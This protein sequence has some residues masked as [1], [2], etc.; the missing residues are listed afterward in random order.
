[1]LINISFHFDYFPLMVVAAIAWGTPILLTLLKLK[2]VPSVIVEI[3]LG[4][5]I[6][7]FLLGS[8]DHE[9][10]RILE[11]FALT[12]FI[13]LMFLGGLEID[14]DQIMASLPRK[15]LTY[16]HFIK[17]PLLVGIVFFF[18]SIILAYVGTL[19]LSNL[20]D[21]P[22]V[23]YFSLIMVTTS[24]GIVLPVLKDR[25]EI[26]NRYGQMIIIAAAIADILSIILFTFTA[27]II[28]NGFQPELLYILGL[29]IIF[30]VFYSLGNKVKNVPVL[31][32][33]AFQLSH[34]ASQIRIRGSIL[35]IMLFVVIAQ[36]IGE[37]A[38]LLG[39]FLIGLV[40]STMLHR[41]RSVML[42]KLD[43]MGYGFFI[44]IFFIMVGIEFDPSAFLEFDQSLI[45]F[46][47]FLLITLFVVKII[48]AFLWRQLFGL[49]KAM[50]GG[51]LMSS[52][53]SLIIAAS[54]IGLEMGVITPGINA[55]FVVMA[56]LTCFISPVVFNWLSPG[57]ILKGD[58]TIIIGASSTAVLLARRLIMHG[59]KSVIVEND[60]ARADEL[61]AKGLN[62]IEGDGC[63]AGLYEELNLHPSDFVI[64]ETGSPETDHEICKLLRN[65]LMHDN[66]ITRS[67]T[68]DIELKLK[69]LGVETIDVIGVLATT[70]ENLIIRPTTYH[71]L[72]ESFEN[73]SVE[74]ILITNKN[75]DGLQVKEVPFH[76][77]AILMMV[78]RENSFYIPH[79]D[80][81]FRTGDILHVFGTNNALQNTKEKVG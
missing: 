70:I 60:K 10:F 81:Y 39:A 71:A 43:G 65:E 1:M 38:V 29:F 62:C 49:K 8:I 80:T 20:I 61:K 13:F 28:K 31:K 50:A 72:V 24:V 67:S 3:I 69:Y 9:S 56:I 14:V 66:I 46:L 75:V 53:L 79:G 44:P 63:N 5:F 27:F 35:L 51:F 73:F 19:F 78:K 68:S 7:K 58:K 15:R 23:W 52:R 25:G 74:E 26:K 33:L 11:F 22:H 12:G 76:K 4:Y 64:V 54:A 48:P 45:W 57:N 32:K 36:F 17:N 21:I 18:L 40:L 16:V 47:V 55:S 30:F 77:D 42:L 41:E 2:K 37:E 6:G 59:K 34:A